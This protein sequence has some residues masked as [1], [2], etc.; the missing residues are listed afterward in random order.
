MTTEFIDKTL[1]YIVGE[2]YPHV[3]D[4]IGVIT[5]TIILGVIIIVGVTCRVFCD[6][7]FKEGCV[8]VLMLIVMLVSSFLIYSYNRDKKLAYYGKMLSENPAVRERVSR[9][10]DELQGLAAIQE[11]E[12]RN[13]LRSK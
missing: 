9:I 1:E 3:P 6:S 13:E 4:T 8:N 7:T 2:M 10:R 5:L 11:K 12:N